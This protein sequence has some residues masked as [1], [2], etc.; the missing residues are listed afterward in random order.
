MKARSNKSHSM[1]PDE[2]VLFTALLRDS[3]KF[4]DKPE[5]ALETAM[6]SPDLSRCADLLSALLT[7]VRSGET[8]ATAMAAFPDVFPKV[9]VRAIEAGEKDG[10]LVPVLDKL[11]EYTESTHETDANE[12]LSRI[13]FD[14]TV[15]IYLCMLATLIGVGQLLGTSGITSIGCLTTISTGGTEG[16]SGISLF[17]VGPIALLIA[18][19]Y[20]LIMRNW[21]FSENSRFKLE[22]IKLRLPGFGPI[23]RAASLSRFSRALGLLLSCGTPKAESLA[24]AAEASGNVPVKRSVSKAVSLAENGEGLSKAL[25][26]VRF[27][28]RSFHWM[29]S[30]ASKSG[31]ASR[32]LLEIASMHEQDMKRRRVSFRGKAF[33]FAVSTAFLSYVA[34]ICLAFGPQF[35]LPM[36]GGGG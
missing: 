23:F 9:Y 24:L 20:Y 36:G 28:G 3:V 18:M 27:L 4:G 13:E 10:D 16:E 35:G 12:K 11:C 26:P 21:D 33:T 1:R 25:E 2:L 31:D 19:G 30:E 14:G 22:A 8:L 34:L 17:D 5:S 29:I 15:V 7:K 6:S 32:T